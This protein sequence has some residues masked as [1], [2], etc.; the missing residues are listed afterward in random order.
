MDDKN[1]PAG[2]SRAEAPVELY[3]RLVQA[4]VDY[5]IY[6]VDNDGRV[7]SWN[8]GAERIKGYRAEE[9]LGTHF[10]RFFTE[11]DRKAGKP[12]RALDTA[13]R[14]G[15][16]EDEGVRV[17][18]DGT[19]FWVTAV[20]DAIRDS[21]GNVIGFAKV[22]RDI[23]ERKE[24]ERRLQEAREQLFRAQKMETLGQFTGGLAHD[25]N[26]LLTAVLGAAELA[27]R[28]AGDNERLKR[29]LDSIRAAAQ[30]GSAITKQLLA[31]ASRQP[32]E[33][34]LIDLNE[35][36]QT[37]SGLIRQSL[38][39]NIELVTEASSRLWSIE[40]DPNQLE[41][42]IL[43]LALNARDAMAD[44]GVVRLTAANRSLDGEIE[45]LVGEFIAISV[46]DKG[47]GIAPEIRNRIFDPFFTT[48]G[49]GQGTGLGLS[50]VYGFAKQ[51][52]GAVAVDTEVGKGT[53]VT[54]YLPARS[55]HVE[56]AEAGANRGRVLVVEDDL[57]LAEMAAELIGEMGYHV[58]VAHNAQE[59]LAIVQR[60][61][62]FNLVFSDVVMPGGMSGLE[63]AR[64]VR[65]RYP[66][67]PILL[68]T[69]FSDALAGRPVEFP[70]LMKPYE[71]DRLSTAV[72]EQVRRAV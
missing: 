19:R 55:T 70:V 46:I 12:Q 9:V 30:R 11:E 8:A 28:Q 1:Q 44:G 65:T 48:K 40:A 59:A 27:R 3:E 4:V 23:T 60:S 50:Q 33:P 38:R 51:S 10:S 53:T 34:K 24:A 14:T 5:A 45:G 16:F 52:K 47:T 64:K 68:T 62:P 37:I 71:P 43:N 66:E 57:M 69:G 18:K 35:Q 22:T 39:G 20:L 32:L 7:T 2:R 56:T 21:A 49:F 6:M 36:L 26:N 25:F 61:G 29:H 67:M 58:Q 41:L 15:R 42:A 17:R 31:F 13:R 54:L 72:S 63:L